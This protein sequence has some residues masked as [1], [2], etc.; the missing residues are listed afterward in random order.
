MDTFC[1]AFSLQIGVQLFIVNKMYD[2]NLS[3]NMGQ[4]TT[5]V[6]DSMDKGQNMINTTTV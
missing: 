1:S 2:P 5:N 4:P 3:I 6:L